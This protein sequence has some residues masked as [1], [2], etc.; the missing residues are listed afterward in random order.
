MFGRILRLLFRLSVVAGVIAGV[1]LF[2]AGAGTYN[3]TLTLGGAALVFW[4]LAVW[5]AVWATP[6]APDTHTISATT[7]SNGFVNDPGT[8]PP[9]R[10][11]SLTDFSA[12]GMTCDV[13]GRRGEQRCRPTSPG[14]SSHPAGEA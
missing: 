14:L 6:R 3:N 2:V 7:I 11:M 12:T 13:R 9:V 5:G 10:S 8:I 4:T 1:V